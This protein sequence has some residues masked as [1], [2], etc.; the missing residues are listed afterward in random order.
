M[1]N[2]PHCQKRIFQKAHDGRIKIRTN[3]LVFKQGGAE[4]VCKRC[5]G[6]IP[7]DVHMGSELKKAVS[8]DKDPKL[9]L[10]KNIDSIKNLP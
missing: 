7:L 5:G 3:I 1:S 6:D 2:C 10:K 9:V 8:L 4:I